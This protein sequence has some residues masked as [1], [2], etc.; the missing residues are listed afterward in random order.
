MFHRRRHCRR[1]R[2]RRR[3]SGALGRSAFRHAGLIVTGKFNYH[4]VSPPLHAAGRNYSPG[5]VT[6]RGD[7]TVERVHQVPLISTVVT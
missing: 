3:R 1:G 4:Y 6:F 2:P 7:A 5:P